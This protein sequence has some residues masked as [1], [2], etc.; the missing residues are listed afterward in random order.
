MPV[1]LDIAVFVIALIALIKSSEWVINNTVKLASYYKIG[2]FA[3]GFLL[4]A[5]ATS[6]PEMAVTV[7]AS[8]Q[9]AGSL[10]LGNVIGSNISNILLILGIAI[11]SAP[12]IVTHKK[13]LENAQVLFV[14]SLIPIIFLIRGSINFVEG[15]ALLALFALYVFFVSRDKVPAIIQPIQRTRKELAKTF[16]FFLGSAALLLLSAQFATN[17]ALNI[18]DFFKLPYSTI[19]LT[20]VAIGTSLPEL[21]VTVTGI[22]KGKQDLV[23]GDII[24]SNIVN[25]TLVLGLGAVLGTI[26]FNYV[27][28][29][30]A[31]FFLLL[32]NLLLVYALMTHKTLRKDIGIVF[33][34]IYAIFLLSE[35]GVI[36][37]S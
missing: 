13:L 14:M 18:A 20:I 24:G 5:V 17:S 7:T 36:G 6:L 1:P 37:F 9:N 34:V 19:G 16:L 10:I 32:A 8:L 3:A 31:L 22:F 21:A 15:L 26:A 29:G 35:I 2:E 25:I 23:L 12:I 27:I 30:S 4:I 28:I 11:L 33:I